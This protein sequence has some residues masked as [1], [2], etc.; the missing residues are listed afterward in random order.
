MR[1]ALI[2]EFEKTRRR[3]VWLIVAAILLVQTVWSLWSIGRMDAQKL[4]HGWM[5]FLY[6]FPLLNAIMMP[7]LAAVVASRLCDMEHKGHML[8]LLHTVMPAGRLFNAKYL[9]GALYMLAAGVL[10]TA[11]MLA[12]GYLWGFAG[13]PPL[14]KLLVYLLFTTA[15]NLALLLLQQ[16]LSFLFVNQMVPLTVGLMGGLVGLF[17]MFFPP[18][19]ERFLLWG[20]YGVLMLVGMN[21]DSSTRISSFYYT[22]VDW[23]GFGTLLLMMCIMYILGR[24][25]F[26]RKEM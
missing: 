20:Y 11:V 7:V 19:W 8:K 3:K 24:T 5:F 13:N 4:A 17:M 15:V 10:Q 26:V 21:W 25:L 2:L 14:A 9:C 12:V 6:Q 22:P 16:T 1:R 18:I 23:A